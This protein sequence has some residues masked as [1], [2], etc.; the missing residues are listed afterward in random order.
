MGCGF[1]YTQIPISGKTGGKRRSFTFRFAAYYNAKD[2][3]L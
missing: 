2:H 1:L 3:L